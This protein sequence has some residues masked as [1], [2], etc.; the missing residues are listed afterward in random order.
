MNTVSTSL[1]YFCSVFLNVV[2]FLNLVMFKKLSVYT[3][4]V[5]I[6]L[7]HYANHSGAKHIF[8][9]VLSKECLFIICVLF[10]A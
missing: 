8:E 10:K 9:N 5:N 2:C 3:G 6:F 7:G 1:M 4:S